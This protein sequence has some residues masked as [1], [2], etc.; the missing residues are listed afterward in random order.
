[1]KVDLNCHNKFA[2]DHY[3]VAA[4][5]LSRQTIEVGLDIVCLK[6]HRFDRGLAAGD[7]NCNAAG[8]PGFQRGEK[9]DQPR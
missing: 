3:Y 4:E 5:A 1:M 6:E 8:V 7:E 2:C 9:F